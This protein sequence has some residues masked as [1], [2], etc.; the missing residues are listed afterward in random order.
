MPRMLNCTAGPLE[1]DDS[2]AKATRNCG[3]NLAWDVYDGTKCATLDTAELRLLGKVSTH[4]LN[5]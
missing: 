4:R 3:A 2:N 1:I 5:A